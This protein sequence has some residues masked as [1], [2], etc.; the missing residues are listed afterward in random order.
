MSRNKIF[1]RDFGSGPDV[2][3]I[4]FFSDAV[5]AIAMTLLAVEIEVP[6]VQDQELAPAVAEQ[7]PQFLAYVLSFVVTGELWLSHHRMFRVLRGFTP[8]LQRLNLLLLLFV[9]VIGYATDM[10]AFYGDTGLGVAI[11]AGVLGIIGAVDSLMWLYCSRRGLFDERYDAKLL[12]TSWLHAGIGPV[13]FLLS[14]PIAFLSPDA[15]K[16]SW[17]AILAINLPLGFRGRRP[18]AD[19]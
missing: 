8:G 19:A 2:E 4:T 3:R 1:R 6:N 16:F 10:L 9:A 12:S 7:L 17:L 11:Y 15:A 5:F 14:I 13:V 18:V